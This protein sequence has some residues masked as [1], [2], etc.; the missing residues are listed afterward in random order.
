YNRCVFVIHV[1]AIVL[2]ESPEWRDFVL[3]PTCFAP[4]QEGVF[5]AVIWSDAPI[6]IR[7]LHDEQRAACRVAH[8]SWQVQNAAVVAAAAQEQR[9]SDADV[10]AAV[11]SAGGCCN[12]ATW[13]CNPKLLLEV[14]QPVQRPL[15]LSLS[16]SALYPDQE[17]DDMNPHAIGFYVLDRHGRD[18][19]K[20]RFSH[21]PEV[22][23][24]LDQT[25]VSTQAALEAHAPLVLVPA[26]FHAGQEA[27]L[28][29]RVFGAPEERHKWQLTVS[30]A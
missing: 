17:V 7:T 25:L 5:R 28:T 29:F 2:E 26:C 20:A 13:R 15:V 1:S 27:A 24:R 10:Q 23:L 19:G 11:G 21:T 12:Y 8:S 30:D 16:Q 3:L 4:G 18:C 6:E 9:W 14:T 22:M